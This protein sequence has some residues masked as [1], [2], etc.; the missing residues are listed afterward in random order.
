MYELTLHFSHGNKLYDVSCSHTTC[1]TLQPISIICIKNLSSMPSIIRWE[2]LHKL[3][4]YINWN[5]NIHKGKRQYTNFMIK[6]K[7]YLHLWK[8][9]ISYSN[10]KNWKGKIR[11]LN[12]SVFC[13]LKVCKDSILGL[14]GEKK[15][16]AFS[17]NK[18]T[19]LQIHTRLYRYNEQYV[20]LVA[21]V[22]KGLAGNLRSPVNNLAEQSGSCQ[23]NI[24]Q[25]TGIGS[26]DAFNSLNLFKGN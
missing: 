8:I 2:R 9:S 3:H 7:S 17:R 12:Q 13:F 22:G 5:N 11:C 20:V 24:V 14:K 26:H 1:A 21:V 18:F 6:E 4:Y 16:G 25:S 15:K 19:N 23:R 10:Y